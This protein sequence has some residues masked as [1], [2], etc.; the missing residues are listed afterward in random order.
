MMRFVFEMMNFASI[1]N[2]V[3][4]NVQAEAAMLVAKQERQEA[5]DAKVT[6]HSTENDDISHVKWLDLH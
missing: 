4:P 1:I 2:C 6:L 5:E 3:I